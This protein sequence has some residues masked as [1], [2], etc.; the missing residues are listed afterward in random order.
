VPQRHLVRL[1]LEGAALGQL[2]GAAVLLLL[3]LEQ[4]ARRQ[5]WPA[6]PPPHLLLLPHL[7]LVLQLRRR[8]QAGAEV[9]AWAAGRPL[10]VRG[11]GVGAGAGAGHPRHHDVLL[12]AATAA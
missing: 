10:V 12:L 3:L 9:V 2:V 11:V 5:Q 4:C 8:A 7:H 6:Q 1:L